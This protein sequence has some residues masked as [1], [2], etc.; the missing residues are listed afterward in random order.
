MNEFFKRLITSLFLILVL[1]IGL[2]NKI[3]L[4]FL[5]IIFIFLLF[6]EFNYM[7]KRIFKKN[8]LLNLFFLLFIYIYLAFFSLYLWS[9]LNRTDPNIELFFIFILSICVSTDIGGYIFGKIFKGKK[10]TSISPNKTYSG[11]IGSYLLPLLVT[12]IFFNKLTYELN[13][14]IIFFLVS[15]FSQIGDLFISYLKRKAKL[16]DTGSILPGHGGLL[17]RV[18]GILFALP[19][20]LI[21]VT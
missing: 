12:T 21:L 15:T 13:Y 4:F 14:L 11:V 6:S 3:F 1:Y 7:L 10:L 17:D 18:D 8:K 20:G 19:L 2:I 16:K 9:F 5:I